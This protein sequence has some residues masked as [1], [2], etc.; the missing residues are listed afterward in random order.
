M[1]AKLKSRNFKLRRR[2][3]Q[4]KDEAFQCSLID[5]LCGY[6]TTRCNRY[7]QRATIWHG[8]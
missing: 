4:Y 8:E 2:W 3:R 7:V 5:A 1:N 6:T